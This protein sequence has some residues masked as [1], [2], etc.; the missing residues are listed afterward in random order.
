MGLNISTPPLSGKKADILW[1]A[2]VFIFV[3]TVY[4]LC[5][6]TTSTDSR[7]T[8]Y[9]SMSMLREQNADLDEYAHLMEDWDFRVV[10]LDDHI[11]SYFPLGVLQ[12]LRGTCEEKLEGPAPLCWFYSGESK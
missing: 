1:S 9:F 2:V 10:Y 7:W 3:F 12:A 4:I 11:Y 6:V 5:P 8:F